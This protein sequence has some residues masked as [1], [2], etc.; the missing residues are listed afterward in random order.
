MEDMDKDLA[1]LQCGG[2]FTFSASE[3][4]F[5]SRKG[6]KYEPKRCPDCRV[7]RNGWR[8]GSRLDTSI[9]ALIQS[10]K[11]RVRQRV[12]GP[13]GRPIWSDSK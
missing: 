3:Q 12:M 2:K 7:V 1:C 11:Y 5:F 6:R 4:E 8:R 10:G 9:Q 13:A